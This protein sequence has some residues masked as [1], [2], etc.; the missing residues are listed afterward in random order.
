MKLTHNKQYIIYTRP[1]FTYCIVLLL[2]FFNMVTTGCETTRA[3]GEIVAPTVNKTVEDV[4]KPL[5]SEA[6][7]RIAGA[8]KALANTTEEGSR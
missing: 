1:N 6:D 8:L 2:I 4:V 7:H 5:A 3:T